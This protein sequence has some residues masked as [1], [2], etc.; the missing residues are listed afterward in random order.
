MAAQFGRRLRKGA[1][2]TTVAALVVAAL[3]ASQAPGSTSAPADERAANATEPPGTPVTGNSPYFT[4]LPPL[5]T[6]NKPNKP[7]TSIDLPAVTGPAESGIPA[8]VLAAYKRAEGTVSD[9]APGCRLP[10]QL[11]AAIGK[12]ESGQARGGRV[13]ANG[14]TLTPILGPQLNGVGFANISDTDNGAYDGDSTHDRA[15]G[16]MQF[17]PSTWA[18]WGQDGNSDGRKDPNNIYDAAL[19]AGRY[20]CAH[21]RDLSV[22]GDLDQA[23][24]GYNRSREYLRTVMSWFDYYR[25][26]SHEV[27]DGS[28]VLPGSGEPDSHRSGTGDGNGNGKG[29]PG[30]PGTPDPGKPGGNGDGSGTPTPP[31][32]QPPATTPPPTTPPPTTP[33]PTTPPAQAPVT[34][35]ERLGSASVTATEGERFTDRL[36]V[37]A[38]TSA[39]KVVAGSRVQFQIIG[40][41]AARFAGA[42]TRI[43]VSTGTDGIA[44]APTLSAGG[45]TGR[46][47]VRAKALG[48]T[49]PAA[50][51]A[52]NVK[53]KPAP[54]PQSDALART[55]DKELTAETGGSFADSVEVKATYKGKVAAGVG[56]SATMVTGDADK[57]VENDKG[58]YFK[59]ADGKA[60]RT[61]TA[62]KTD[63]NG[64]LKLPEIYTDGNAGTYKLRLT[65]ADGVVLTVELTVTAPTTAPTTDPSTS[66]SA[67][68]T[69]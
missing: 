14:T 45:Q 30:A 62:L 23:I 1:T 68:P 8:T 3:S 5:N 25:R 2:A 26:D 31:P 29:S 40:D 66:P 43:V 48:T 67:T 55:S 54:V 28:G 61:L 42:E 41:T 22:Q 63:A 10:W 50:D 57:P 27:P 18:T 24:L 4:D 17:I 38:K 9:T 59:D 6:P 15:V 7:G 13:D 21:N 52:A 20:L 19:A 44:T 65:T 64:L 36:R 46:F 47:I 51:F 37:R 39:G 12:V 49:A 35:L 33:P 32:T 53:A 16:P 69:A 56:V 11:L 58:P 60:V 34:T